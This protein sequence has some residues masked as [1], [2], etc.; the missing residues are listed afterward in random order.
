MNPYAVYMYIYMF[1]GSKSDNKT[2]FAHFIRLSHV[3]VIPH[4]FCTLLVHEFK[5]SVYSN[6]S[7]CEKQVVL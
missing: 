6:R 2:G 1:C 4:L 7:V 5:L 3:S